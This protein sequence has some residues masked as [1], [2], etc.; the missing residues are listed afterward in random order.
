[1][2]VYA[3]TQALGIELRGKLKMLNSPDHLRLK[4][5]L[6]E[7]IQ[8]PIAAEGAQDNSDVCKWRLR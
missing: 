4:V 6:I 8:T 2:E 5:F 1:M 7:V 3:V